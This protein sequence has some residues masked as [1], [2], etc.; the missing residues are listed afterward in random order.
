MLNLYV[1]TLYQILNEL[2]HIAS[3]MPSISTVCPQYA[4]CMMV[5]GFFF[6][7]MCPFIEKKTIIT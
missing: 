5:Q 4:S 1:D 6:Y 7:L 2:L 3:R